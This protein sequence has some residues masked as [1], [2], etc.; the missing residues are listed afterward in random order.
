MVRDNGS[1]GPKGVWVCAAILAVFLIVSHVFQGSS[2][3]HS[4][5]LSP[6]TAKAATADREK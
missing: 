3:S 2:V 1:F 5:S 4:R 6:Q